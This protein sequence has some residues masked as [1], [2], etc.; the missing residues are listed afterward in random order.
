MRQL[1]SYRVL[2]NNYVIENPIPEGI[3]KEIVID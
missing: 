1:I 3:E 2:E